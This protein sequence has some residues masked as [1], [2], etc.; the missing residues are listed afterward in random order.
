MAAVALGQV[1]V[2]FTTAAAWYPVPWMR[3]VALGAAITPLLWIHAFRY[4]T[5]PKPCPGR[6]ARRSYGASVRRTMVSVPSSQR[7]CT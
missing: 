6:A 7:H 3:A 4:D 1:F 5:M 2:V